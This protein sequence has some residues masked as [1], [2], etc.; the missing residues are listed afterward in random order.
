VPNYSLSVP[1]LRSLGL[2]PVST[3]FPTFGDSWPIKSANPTG[4]VCLGRRWTHW[5]WHRRA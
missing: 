2:A 5:N 4:L 1:L 3:P